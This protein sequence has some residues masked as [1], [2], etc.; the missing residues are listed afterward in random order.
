MI[1]KFNSASLFKALGRWAGDRCHGQQFPAMSHDLTSMMRSQNKTTSFDAF[2]SSTTP[3][4]LYYPAAVFNNSIQL[5]T[6]QRTQ[7]AA[8]TFLFKIWNAPRL[9][10]HAVH[11][12]GR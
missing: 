8:S 10:E 11:S 7:S 4:C 3:Q 6:I 2:N 1:K 12:D 9:R 5:G